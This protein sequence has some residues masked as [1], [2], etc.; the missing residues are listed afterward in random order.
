[1]QAAAAAAT[2]TTPTTHC[3]TAATKA[4]EASAQAQLA[5]DIAPYASS[6]ALVSAIAA[7]RQGLDTAW[8]ALEQPYCGYGSYGSAS[9]VHSYD[10]TVTRARDAFLALARK[11]PTTQATKKIAA[12]TTTAK[13]TAVKTSAK[14]TVQK[15]LVPG[16]SGA[17]ISALQ[18]VL[19]QYFGLPLDASHVT[20]YFGPATKKLVIKFQLVRNIIDSA[21]SPGAGQVGPKTAAALNAL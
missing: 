6:T 7:Y 1:M 3:V 2:T 21:T 13:K 5:K 10:K 9:A 16:M 8:S 15:N 18:K 20:G 17:A 4:L 19:A 12:V 11:T 14:V